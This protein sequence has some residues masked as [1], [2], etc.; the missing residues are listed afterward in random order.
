MTTIKTNCPTCGEVDLTVDDIEL[1]LSSV[2]EKS[3]Y[4]FECPGCDD[5][6]WKPADDRIVQLLISGGVKASVLPDHTYSDLPPLTYDDLLDFHF[7]LENGSLLEDWLN[8]K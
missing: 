5:F 3:Q 2:G 4:G 6:V 1:R 7:A 8:L